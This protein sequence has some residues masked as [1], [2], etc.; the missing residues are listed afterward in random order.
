MSDQQLGWESR[1]HISKNHRLFE[2]RLITIF[3]ECMRPV[4]LPQQSLGLVSTVAV[5]QMHAL[6]THAGHLTFDGIT[7]GGRLLKKD[8]SA[9]C[10][11]VRRD[12]KRRRRWR[13][14]CL[15]YERGVSLGWT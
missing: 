8:T 3:Y 7:A 11:A 2:N 12:R 5:H 1:T 10:R 4:L 14:G 9:V 6:N 13:R 15:A